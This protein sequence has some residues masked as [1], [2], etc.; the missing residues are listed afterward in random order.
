MKIKILLLTLL[1][2]VST[3]LILFI[4]S[5]SLYIHSYEDWYSFMN[6][7]TAIITVVVSSLML[8]L[9][10]IGA[11]VIILKMKRSHAKNSFTQSTH[12]HPTSKSI[13]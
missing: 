2:L 7:D 8:V 11:V 13:Y 12:R 1:G 10:L 9:A 5:M 6:L 3:S 4:I